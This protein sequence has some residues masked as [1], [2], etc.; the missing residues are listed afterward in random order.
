MEE[1]KGK[2]KHSTIIPLIG[3]SI[4]GITE[5]TG[6]KP[7]YHL[8]YKEFS[9]NEGYLMNYW[10]DVPRYE[11]NGEDFDL[12]KA[13]YVDAVNS[14][15]P[16]AGLSGL[17]Q[18]SHADNKV[19]QWLY[20]SSEFVLQNVKPKVLWGENAPAL[21]TNKGRKVAEKLAAIGRKHGYSYSMIK[22]NTMEH[23]IPQSR[24]RT[25]FFF[26]KSKTAPIM[27]YHYTKAPHLV[28]F[29]KQIP[30][31]ATQQDNVLGYKPSQTEE[32]K[33]VMQMEKFPSHEEMQKQLKNGP[34]TM[35]ILEKYGYD[36]FFEWCDQ[37]K[38]TKA[39]ERIRKKF[40]YYKFKN[41]N[42]K[43]FMDGSPCVAYDSTNAIIGRQLTR[44]MHPTEDRFY[45][46]R[47]L[48]HMMGLPMDFELKD[49]K[50]LNVICQSV[51]TVTTRDMMKEVVRFCSDDP[52]M[53][54]APANFVIQD[55]LNKCIIESRMVW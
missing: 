13:H 26:W 47:E 12:S 3:G 43:G 20:E 7:D 25:F 10:P 42:D 2:I 28:D 29:L 22:T 50:Q 30:K 24:Q 15:C 44:Y 27:G 32:Y 19:N 46:I 9:F 45:T 17:S 52:T 31:D 49:Y 39:I 36:K 1:N 5:Y 37:Q 11:I 55:N 40:E 18:T 6:T 51:P 41:D 53:V 21:A 38:Q 14:V 33:F 23:G 35:F 48:M 34:L 4:F 8:S 16:C 54:L